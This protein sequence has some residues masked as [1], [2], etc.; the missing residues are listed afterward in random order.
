MSE[1]RAPSADVCSALMS[2]TSW[3]RACT[4]LRLGLVTSGAHVPPGVWAVQATDCVYNELVTL[5]IS[6]LQ[7]SSTVLCHRPPRASVD[8]TETDA[9]A[10]LHS[11]TEPQAIAIGTTTAA[12]YCRADL[13]YSSRCRPCLCNCSLTPRTST[14][15]LVHPTTVLVACS[16]PS[17]TTLVML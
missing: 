1:H 14:S 7:Y 3:K 15:P 12:S 6:T 13:S 17:P 9:D 8:M 11:R 10:A 2:A 16:F 5:S 4:H